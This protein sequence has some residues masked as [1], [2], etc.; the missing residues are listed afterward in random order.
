[1]GVG[2][3]VVIGKQGA[4][5]GTQCVRLAERYGVPHVATGDMLRAAVRSGSE[6]GLRVK[7]IMDEGHLVPDELI[8]DVVASRLAEPD[9]AHGAIL[10]G[11]PRT[12]GQA[13]ALEA[14]AK[15]RGLTVAVLLDVPTDTVIKRLSARR[16]CENC[17]TVYSAN[18]PPGPTVCSNCGGRV[19]QRADDTP[20]AIAE[21]LSVYEKATA[22]LLDFYRQRGLLSVVDGSASL[23]EVFD[24]VVAAVDA[25]NG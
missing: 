8:T 10:D 7:A 16:V 18:P 3:L 20:E 12:L 1:V 6:L 22:P 19:V 5:K 13:E 23:D 17:Q 14:I 15:P 25:A 21:R 4:G 24:R 11:Y 2:L 9:A